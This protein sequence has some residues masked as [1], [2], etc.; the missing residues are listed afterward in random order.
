MADRPTDPASGDGL[1]EP[2]AELR[3]G[4]PATLKALAD[5]LRVRILEEMATRM[6]H[7]WTVKELAANLGTR[8]TSLYHHVN[9]LEERGIIRVAAT[10]TVSGITLRRYQLSAQDFRVDPPALAGGAEA[11]DAVVDA[12]IGD[13]RSELR[14]VTARRRGARPGTKVHVMRDT[15]RLDPAQAAALTRQ[16]DAL[17][18]AAE[19]EASPDAIPHRFVT[20]LFA[21]P[22]AARGS[23]R[24]R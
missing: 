2:P 6:R 21:L 16:I 11:A 3:I 24:R 22:A 8:L 9:L 13:L 15:A 1:P 7:G 5:P 12:L 20:A 4:D 18:R 17:L 19:A 10:A 23:A 14:V